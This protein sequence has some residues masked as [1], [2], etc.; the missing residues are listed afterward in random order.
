MSLRL[1]S[2]FCHGLRLESPSAATRP[3]AGRVR[4][5]VWNALQR[6]L[7]EARVLD[8]C[9]GSGAVGIEALSRG[10]QSATFIEADR[11]AL[12]ALER[13]LRAVNERAAKQGLKIVT[14]VLPLPANKALER[15]SPSC[16]D[17]V[18]LDPPYALV[19][20]MLPALRE[21]LSRVASHRGY[22]VIESAA[23]DQEFVVACLEA[24]MSGWELDRR[25][26]YGE[27]AV[28]F[29]RRRTA[30][31]P[32]PGHQNSPDDTVEGDGDGRQDTDL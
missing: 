8:I 25:K 4:S 14:Q 17:I 21:H 23:A 3:T 1:T 2:G 26:L 27:I 16:F 12:K 22:L 20:D 13:N 6:D 29:F 24:P 9:A 18:W 30:G 28:S 31:D 19:R 15:C 11:E 5:A 10:A 7:A 32:L